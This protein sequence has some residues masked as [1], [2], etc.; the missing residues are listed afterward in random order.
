RA[1]GDTSADERWRRRA[2]SRVQPGVTVRG[3]VAVWIAYMGNTSTN[4]PGISLRL[5]RGRQPTRA[6]GGHLGVAERE[7]YQ[8]GCGTCLGFPSTVSRRGLCSVRIAVSYATSSDRLR[9]RSQRRHRH[10]LVRPPR[11]RWPPRSVGGRVALALQ[12]PRDVERPDY[13]PRRSTDAA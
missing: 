7:R 2:A 3:T 10:R 8:L 9:T 1:E 11:D 13:R 5:Q 6:T 4:L 12:G